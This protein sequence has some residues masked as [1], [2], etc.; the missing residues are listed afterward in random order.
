MEKSIQNP[1]FDRSLDRI[2]LCDTCL[3][4]LRSIFLAHRGAGPLCYEVLDDCRAGLDDGCGFG[5]RAGGAAAGGSDAKKGLESRAI[6]LC[7]NCA[8]D[9]TCVRPRPESGVWHCE[10]Y[11]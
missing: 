7:A 5:C 8:L 6:G 9:D 2:G 3:R 4:T 11:R 1:A 10:D